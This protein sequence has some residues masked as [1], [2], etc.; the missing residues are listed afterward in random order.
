[1]FGTFR[2][3]DINTTYLSYHNIPLPSLLGILGAVN[4]YS[5]RYKTYLDDCKYQK[6]LKAY[7]KEKG[8]FDKQQEKLKN[9]S[10][11]RN[12]IS[13]PE[14]PTAP[15]LPDYYTK[16]QGTFIGIR[17]IERFTKKT[18]VKYNNYHGYGSNEAGGMWNIQEQILIN[19][20]WEIYV[21]YDEN[22]QAVKDLYENLKNQKSVFTP[23]LGKNEFRAELKFHQDLDKYENIQ[24]GKIKTSTLIPHYNDE[25]VDKRTKIV[26]AGSLFGEDRLVHDRENNFLMLEN[27]P[28]SL[29]KSGHYKFSRIALTNYRYDYSQESKRLGKMIRT[30]S[31]DIF[32][33]EVK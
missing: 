6:E 33:F 31:E 21:E 22:N 2:K 15:A 8:E 28:I 19:P 10:K 9:G 17:P 16:F 7:V 3:P 1:M 23:Y 25:C 12:I 29:E 11:L 32:L 5:G 30:S 27:L 20:S 14:K 13:E 26:S 18:N 24:Y 4:G